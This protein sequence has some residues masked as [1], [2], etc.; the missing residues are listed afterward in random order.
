MTEP[1]RLPRAELVRNPTYYHVLLAATVEPG[2]DFQVVVPVTIN[3]DIPK[4]RTYD[5]IKNIVKQAAEGLGAPEGALT[6]LATTELEGEPFVSWNDAPDE[7][8]KI[9]LV[10]PERH[11]FIPGQ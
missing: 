11:L 9:Q 1:V 7:G 6:Y 2:V 5:E 3:S 10:L 8:P 4:P